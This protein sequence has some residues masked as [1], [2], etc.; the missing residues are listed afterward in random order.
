[1]CWSADGDLE[2]AG[3]AYL[4][5]VDT[6]HADSEL[7]LWLEPVDPPPDQQVP[8]DQQMS[9]QVTRSE[10]PAVDVTSDDPRRAHAAAWFEATIDSALLTNGELAPD[11]DCWRVRLELSHG[12]F[13]RTGGF[14]R[15]VDSGSAGRP[16]VRRLD[17]GLTAR[18]IW[19]PKSGGL[20]LQ[21]SRPEITATVTTSTDGI[22]LQVHDSDWTG[23]APSRI[24]IAAASGEPMPGCELSEPGRPSTPDAADPSDLVG[25]IPGD[26]LADLPAD[27]SGT[28]VALGAEGEQHVLQSSTQP[29]GSR[30]PVPGRA[31]VTMS[32]AADGSWRLD[33]HQHWAQLE[34]VRLDP[35][36]NTMVVTGR[37][38]PLQGWETAQ[39]EGQRECWSG[40]LQVTDGPDPLTGVATFTAEIGLS[41]DDRWGHRGLAPLGG[42]YE[43]ELVGPDGRSVSPQID[44][45]FVDT[46]PERVCTDRLSCQLERQRDDTLRITFSSGLTDSE[47]G[48]RHQAQ[49]QTWSRQLEGPLVDAVYFESFAGK[50]AACSPRAIFD[51][52]QEVAP[53]L[54]FYWGIRDHAVPVPEGSVAVQMHSR[55]W[56]RVRTT[57]RFLVT[58]AWMQRTFVKR[59]GQQVLQ[60]WHGTPYKRLAL[61]REGQSKGFA[62]AVRLESSKW[63]HLVAQSDYM[64]EAMASAYGFTGDAL[65]S[66]YPRN[67]IVS[68]PEGDSVRRSMRRRLGIADDQQCLLYAPT[69]REDRSTM[70]DEL[71]LTE[72]RRQLGEQYVVLARGHG[73]VLRRDHDHSGAGVIDVTSYPDVT[74]LFLAAD[75]AMT[76]Y[77]SV[78]FDY[79][80]T[81]KPLL[82][83]VP[84]LDRY[85]STLR[86]T[87]F[88]L[89]ELAPGPLLTDLAGVVEAVRAV[90]EVRDRYAGKYRDWQ[91]RFNP[92]DDGSAADRVVAAVFAEAL[93]LSPAA[94]GGPSQA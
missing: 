85:T 74:H 84:D 49:L 76:D 65:R 28:L 10:N 94:A 90:D 82:F 68:R 79:T 19:K 27:Y 1:M 83:F 4:T 13:V 16:V 38:Y 30:L 70:V 33:K 92:W 11:V 53:Q 59:P 18:P 80:A 63:D 52:L 37:L 7:R 51:R 55:E 15:R 88:D 67:D 60:T 61:D 57:S 58:N 87:Y 69:W 75:L 3:W 56:W 41:G 47:R 25:R 44:G 21:L 45:R 78:M 48:K 73:N 42:R 77:S 29:A 43:L 35:R 20:L 91:Q 72:L 46:L 36:G 23:V 34:Q 9:I 89:A 50:F 86:G 81:G 14:A 12:D 2:L 40:Q 22:E 31:D 93:G 32:V 17:N 39:L 62:N 8:S 54:Q 71:D 5:G 6:D 24:G 26:V 66:G 64:A